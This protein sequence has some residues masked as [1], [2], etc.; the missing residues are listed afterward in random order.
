MRKQSE[1]RTGFSLEAYQY[2]TNVKRKMSTM[3]LIR[4]NYA[5]L[6]SEEDYWEDTG[7]IVGDPDGISDSANDITWVCGSCGEKIIG[8]TMPASC[9]ACSSTNISEE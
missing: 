4:Q 2:V 1:K 6:E 9:P 5:D 3:D 7:G 8:N